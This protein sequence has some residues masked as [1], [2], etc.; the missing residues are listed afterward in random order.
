MDIGHEIAPADNRLRDHVF[1]QAN[2]VWARYGVSFMTINRWVK[3]ERVGFPQPVYI[4]RFRYWRL[5][6]L[7][8]WEAKQ[9]RRRVAKL[10][11]GKS[12]ADHLEPA[13]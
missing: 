8:E 7:Q 2:K 4:G 3:D 12:V 6:E 13:A 5:T 9:P 11:H 1:L 10:P